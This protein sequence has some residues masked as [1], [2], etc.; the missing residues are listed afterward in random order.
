MVY[1]TPSKKILKTPWARYRVSSMGEVQGGSTSSKSTSASLSPQRESWKDRKWCNSGGLVH[2]TSWTGHFLCTLPF[3]L[4]S[5][6]LTCHHQAAE[7]MKRAGCVLLVAC[8]QVSC[9]GLQNSKSSQ[10][11]FSHSYFFW[12]WCFM[13]LSL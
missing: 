12:L 7:G 8:F 5:R 3:S 1:S 11:P 2:I 6:K 4:C 13:S 10:V 9:L